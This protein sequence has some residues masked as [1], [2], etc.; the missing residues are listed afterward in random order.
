MQYLKKAMEVLSGLENTN[1]LGW[2]MAHNN[3]MMQELAKKSG[4]VPHYLEIVKK[5]K[6]EVTRSAVDTTINPL[7]SLLHPS[8]SLS[9]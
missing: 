5:F 1:I 4:A 2:I 7:F 8:R 9:I 3:V 6:G